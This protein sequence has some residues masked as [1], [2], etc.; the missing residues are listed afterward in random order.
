MEIQKTIRT[1]PKKRKSKSPDV[2]KSIG[3][4]KGNLLLL[5]DNGVRIIVS[6]KLREEKR[7]RRIGVI[8]M[9]QK[10]IEIRR[11]RAEHLFR[12]MDAY[13]LN[14]KL[15]ADST[16]FDKVCITDEHCRWTI[17]KQYLIDNGKILNFSQQGFEI[18]TF[19]ALSDIEIFKKD[20]IL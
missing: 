1:Q 2:I 3:D 10:K 14:Y 19:I 4:D 18:Q 17:P 6:L 9:K 11:N 7:Y 12:K 8:N 16:K 13:G 5:K 20:L 15:L